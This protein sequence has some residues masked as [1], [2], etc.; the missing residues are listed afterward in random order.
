MSPSW[1]AVGHQRAGPQ[2]RAALGGCRR[3]YL[4][5]SAE[6][7][8]GNTSAAAN[9]TVATIDLVSH[10]PEL[11]APSRCAMSIR[12]QG[13]QHFCT[14]SHGH[15]VDIGCDAYVGSLYAHSSSTF[16][17]GSSCDWVS[18]T[19]RRRLYEL[20]STV[21]PSSNGWSRSCRQFRGGFCSVRV[22]PATCLRRT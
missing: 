7:F 14:N 5:A 16:R 19:S 1:R 2:R 20:Q 13:E 8:L 3:C 4:Q 9:P 11:N 10:G 6:T 22:S 21:L 17:P 15:R 12:Y 18:D